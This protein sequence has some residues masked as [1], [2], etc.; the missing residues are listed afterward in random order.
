MA[1]FNFATAQF[2][3]TLDSFFEDEKFNFLNV[4]TFKNIYDL[5]FNKC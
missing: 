5:I 4:L 3:F 2:S 1:L